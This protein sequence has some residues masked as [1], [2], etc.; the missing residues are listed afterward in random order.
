LRPSY[1]IG[2]KGAN[3]MDRIQGRVVSVDVKQVVA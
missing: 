1:Q 3:K 2:S